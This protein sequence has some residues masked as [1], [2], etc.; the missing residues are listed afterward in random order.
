MAILGQA[1]VDSKN[2]TL[3][4]G[5]FPDHIPVDMTKIVKRSKPTSELV[6]AAMASMAESNAQLAA[7]FDKL[8]GA[9]TGKK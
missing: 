8:A 9:L 4:S 3:L 1:R 5:K 7:A 2:A 6:A